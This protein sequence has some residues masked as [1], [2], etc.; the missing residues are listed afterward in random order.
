MLR[1]ILSKVIGD[2]SEKEINRLQPLVDDINAL[3]QTFEA[4]TDEE[5][6]AKTHEFRQRLVRGETLEDLLV[7]A[8]AAVREASKRVTGM[9]HFM[10]S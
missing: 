4:L 5:L 10:C 6:R 7:E 2:P 9:R 1:G 8:F 3:E